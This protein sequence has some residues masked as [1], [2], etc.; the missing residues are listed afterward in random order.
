VDASCQCCVFFSQ[1]Y[2]RR[3]CF[4]SVLCVLQSEVSETWM[5]LVSGVCSSVIGILDVDVSCQCCVFFIQSYLRRGC[6]LS[7]LCVL[8]S[9]VSETRMSLVSV[10]FFSQKCL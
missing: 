5:F 3:G 2:L 4:L 9:E 7:V 10:V 1:R 6:L 8:Q